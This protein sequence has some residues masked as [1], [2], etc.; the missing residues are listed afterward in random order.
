MN[1]EELNELMYQRRAKRQ[2]LIDSGEN[3]YKTDFGRTDKIAD[4]TARYEGLEDGESTSDEVSVAGRILAL[5]EHGKAS[6]A[7]LREETAQ[8]QLFLT[9]DALGEDSYKRFLDLDIGDWAG[10]TGVMLKTRRGELSVKV[11]EWSLLT[12]S[13][14]PLPE[15]WHGLTDV[16]TRYRQRYVDLIANPQIFD[17]F[18]SRIRILDEIRRWLNERGFVE[19]ETPMLQPIPGGATARPFET[20]HNA[21]DA[22]LYL[23]IAPELYLKRLIVGGFERIYEL[24]R[25]FRNEGISIKHN[26][27]FTMLELYEAFSDVNGMRE[28]TEALLKHV[29][30][31]IGRWPALVYQGHEIDF[32]GEWRRAN[33]ID[34]VREKVEQEVSYRMDAEQLRLV[35]RGHEIEPEE[36]WGAGKMIYELFEKLVE[37]T[38]VQPTFVFGY[39]TEVTPLAKR[40]E[41]NPNVTERFE[42]IVGGRELANAFTEL[43][44]PVDQRE[45]FAAQVAMREAGDEEAQYMDEDF[46]RALE[47][48]MPPTGGLGIGIDRL[49]MLLTD[50][51][52]I[53]DVLL[54]PQLRPER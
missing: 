36:S 26:P 53:R 54:F 31:R 44:D 20:Y 43:T 40:S 6:F 7:V 13:L 15:K 42:L 39:P 22:N 23:R 24:G 30:E 45:R 5:R 8:I 9:V 51:A 46:L 41:D 34:L 12:K 27:E 29:A 48:G 35:L 18:L 49:V 16:E 17:V 50:S 4:L 28:L 38:L 11:S 32:A 1:G 52:S 10:A 33:L 14:R 3:P 19:V 47:Y 21:L 37:H 25:N 2:A